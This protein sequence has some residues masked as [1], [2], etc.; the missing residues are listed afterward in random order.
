[1]KPVSLIVAISCLLS[2]APPPAPRPESQIV[3]V[4][5]RGE[6]RYVHRA[7]ADLQA[8]I[9]F[10]TGKPLAVVL[11]SL[12]DAPDHPHTRLILVGQAAREPASR[13]MGSSDTGTLGAEGYLIRSVLPKES[14]RKAAAVLVIGPDSHGTNYGVLDLASRFSAHPDTAL[15]RLDVRE[16]PRYALRGMHAHQHWQYNY[17]YALRSWKLEDWQRYI[18]LLAQLRFNLVQIWSAA[19]IIPDPPEA[20][21]QAYLDRYREIIRYAKE[22]RG[23]REVWIG[24]CADNIATSTHGMPLEKQLPGA[25]WTLV[26]D[27]RNLKTAREF[28]RLDRSVFFPYGAVE[29]EPAPPMTVIK[30]ATIRDRYRALAA[31]PGIAGVMGNA[32]TPLVQLPNIHF[33]AEL[34]WNPAYAE[35]RDRE[36][37]RDLAA[38]LYPRVALE[39]AG[40]WYQL[41]GGDSAACAAAANRL[42]L[43]RQRKQLGAPG[44]MATHLFPDGSIVLEDLATTLRMHA[45]AVE[46]KARMDAEQEDTT[47]IAAALTGYLTQASILQRRNGFHAAPQGDGKVAAPG[48]AWLLYGP[49]Y[50]GLRNAW[51][52]Y[53]GRDAARSRAVIE[54][55]SKRLHGG[56]F[57]AEVCERMIDFLLRRPR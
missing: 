20:A 42:D 24:E 57:D 5:D 29:T 28:N 16:K 23:F 32:Q 17:P 41:A 11:P 21:D 1:V 26:C 51:R 39:L 9:G 31:Y 55:V 37:F 22:E 46:A 25:F 47:G 27:E 38:K 8:Q 6:P 19:G 43:L 30:Y 35:R 56:G 52:R 33:F 34:A 36:G 10:S 3:I 2:A 54:S 44:V 53:P 40:A 14:G 18:D 45:F 15:D 49:D 48:R 13:W 7:V 50:D 4:V 12:A